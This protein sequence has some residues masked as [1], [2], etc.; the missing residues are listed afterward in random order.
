MRSRRDCFLMGLARVPWPCFR[1]P[2]AR[3]SDHASGIAMSGLNGEG[4]GNA[5]YITKSND[6]RESE[7]GVVRS[8]SPLRHNVGVV[9]CLGVVR[10]FVSIVERQG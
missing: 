4:L 1:H 9:R 7:M 3:V 5:R 2:S 6:R 10:T 8:F